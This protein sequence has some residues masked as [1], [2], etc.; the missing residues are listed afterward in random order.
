M[1]SCVTM[2]LENHMFSFLVNNQFR[3]RDFYRAI[4]DKGA[5]REVKKCSNVPICNMTL[6][7]LSSETGI[8]FFN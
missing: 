3:A 6:T 8:G 1:I 2:G 7:H 4:V 5:A